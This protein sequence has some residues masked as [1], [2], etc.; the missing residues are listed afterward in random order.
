MITL[1]LPAPTPG[2]IASLN[3]RT[4]LDHTASND[5][6]TVLMLS[7]PAPQFGEIDA[8]AVEWTMRGVAAALGALPA[9]RP[10]PTIGARVITAGGDALVWFAG[11]PYALRLTHPRWTQTITRLGRVLLAVGLDEL[12][13]VASRAEV[14]EYIEG[15]RASGRMHVALADVGT[16]PRE[17]RAALSLAGGAR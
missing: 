13:P 3:V 15:S 8:D 10:V 16:S 2:L 17:A 9:D 1:A 6:F 12:S 4:W 5:V 14:D 7:Y 11:C